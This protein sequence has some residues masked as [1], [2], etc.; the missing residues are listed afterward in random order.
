METNELEYNPVSLSE[1]DRDD[2][3]TALPK[4]VD[5]VIVA[6]HLLVEHLAEVENGLHK[7]VRSARKFGVAVPTWTIG[8]E[9]QHETR[10]WFTNHPDEECE[11]SVDPVFDVTLNVQE[12]LKL[13]GDWVLMAE[14]DH[15]TD[16]IRIE[17]H[18]NHIA[19][20]V[21]IPANF[22]PSIDRCDHCNV[23]HARTKSFII[24]NPTDGEWM[25]VGR[26]CLTKFLGINPQ[27]FISLFRA[28]N[29]II[30]GCNDWAK[31]KAQYT[32][33]SYDVDTIANMV[34]DYVE[35]YG[36]H[37]NEWET[38][39]VFGKFAGTKQVR[40]NKGESTADML[41]SRLM[42]D[43]FN[44]MIELGVPVWDHKIA[45]LMELNP[46]TDACVDDGVKRVSPIPVDEIGDHRARVDAF[47]AYL[48][49][50]HTANPEHASGFEEWCIKIKHEVGTGKRIITRN[51]NTVASAYNWYL[52]QLATADD[53][54]EQDR[55]NAGLVWIG[56][57]GDKVAMTLTVTE[58]KEFET[59]FGWS[60]IYK[61]TDADGNLFVKF[62][63]INHRYVSNDQF[64]DNGNIGE[65]TV[66]EA[67]FEI[68]KHT[69][70]RGAKQTQ[71]G[72]LSKFK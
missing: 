2:M 46:K 38:I 33:L 55:I 37:K 29:K 50:M 47:R 3:G 34:I 10:V 72:R 20:D 58:V 32:N 25:Q 41:Q 60:S 68:K 70:F 43:R 39:E 14:M 52:N 22:T 53:R 56:E 9:Y 13:P 16:S 63:K 54:A 21:D 67:S 49:D 4:Q 62:G 6:K 8:E 61:M 71:L 18:F 66:I 65:G 48:R 11:W 5:G 15:A 57:V 44:K 59:D 12:T 23:K 69:E 40:S 31:K 19:W 7:L 27:S 35:K 42:T 51:V 1:H 24:H 45:E 26:G 30:G 28:I 64:D 17:D 36:Y